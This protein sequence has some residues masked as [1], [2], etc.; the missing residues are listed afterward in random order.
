MK[1]KSGLGKFRVSL[2]AALL[3]ALGASG[4]LAATARAG[5]PGGTL[6]QAPA[7][8]GKFIVYLANGVYKPNDP[9]YKAPTADFFFRHIMGWN[10]AQIA[11]QKA[12]ALAFFKQRFGVDVSPSG[13][14]TLSAIYGGSQSQYRAYVVSGR[15][16]PRTGWLV[17]DG[18]WLAT[19]KK[20]G[21][22][23]YGPYGGRAGIRVPGGA[24]VGYGYYNIAAQPY[25]II[26]H[27]QSHS[28]MMFDASGNLGF[29]C[30]VTNPRFGHGF[31]Q[32]FAGPALKLPGGF[33]KANIRNVLTFPPD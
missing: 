3:L 23:L 16:V 5:S 33:V 9:S 10:D 14:A 15:V 32:G 22:V 24:F 19:I 18:G 12:R 31:A 29:Q 4:Y 17:R 25:P 11:H 30:E 21:A 27:W 20:G 8:Y 6:V 1:G 13:N 28:P 26:V 7:G 2:V